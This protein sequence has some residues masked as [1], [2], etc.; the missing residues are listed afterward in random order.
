MKGINTFTLKMIAIVS[1]L[2]DHAGAVLFPQYEI[3]RIVGRL[4]FPIYAYT[5]V[6]GLV[7]THDVKKYMLRLGAFALIS[8]IPFDLAF[9]G[10]ALEFSH[11]NVF[12]TL[13]LGIVML[14]FTIKAPTTF[15]QFMYTIGF[16]LISEFLRTDYNSMGLLMIFCFYYFRNQNVTKYLLVALINILFMGGTQVYAVLALVP[17]AMHNGNQGPKCK[18]FFYGFYPVH[19]LILYFISLII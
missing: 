7:H 4:A 14:Y 3:L 1:M 18:K 10:S 17:I 15:W 12:F 16:F 5:L 11:Q 9:F 13:F 2:I 6:E 19:L 8:E